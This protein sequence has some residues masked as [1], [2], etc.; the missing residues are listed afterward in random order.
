MDMNHIVQ[1]A[2]HYLVM[3]AILFAVLTFIRIA[4]GDVNFWVGLAIAVAIGVL[5]RPVVRRL[6]LA[7]P[8]WDT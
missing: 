1:V 5:Y 3:I 4:F 7:P 2:P 6:E 8:V